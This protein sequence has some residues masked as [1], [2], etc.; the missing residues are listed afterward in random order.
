MATR[1]R[2]PAVTRNTILDAALAEFAAG[3]FQGGGLNRLVAA[4]GITKG[5]FFH[6]FPDKISIAAALLEERF[7]P[8]VEAAWITPLA[9]SPDPLATLEACLRA[10]ARPQHPPAADAGLITGLA[11][12]MTTL[13]AAPRDAFTRLLDDW[14]E[15]LADALSRGKSSGKIHPSINP[16]AEAALLLAC[17]AGLAATAKSAP[18]NSSAPT[19][20]W[21]A[22]GGYIDTLRAPAN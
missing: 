21:R 20:A 16:Q 17:L 11:A 12:E 18:P 3:G 9:D 7:R 1:V 22:L 5:A 19:L 8:A 15:S 2:Q 13:H 4:A 6:H 10:A 14:R